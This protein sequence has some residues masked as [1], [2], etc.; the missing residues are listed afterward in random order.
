[1]KYIIVTL[2]SICSCFSTFAQ[3]QKYLEMARIDSISIKRAYLLSQQ[4]L[5]HDLNSD[6]I[7][8][9]SIKDNI[10]L[11]RKRDSSCIINILGKRLPVTDLSNYGECTV[12]SNID[13]TEILILCVNY[14]GY[15]NQYDRF[16][17]VPSHSI[18]QSRRIRQT[19]FKKFCSGLGAYIGCDMKEIEKQ[20]M[21]MKKVQYKTAEGVEIVYSQ[22]L[23]DWP[24]HCEY[25]FVNNRLTR[26]EFDYR[27]P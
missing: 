3:A 7:F 5:G 23:P 1:M 16:V 21:M 24:Y 11:G 8:V 12:C 15:I 27:D 9:F 25:H 13:G 22:S 20:M 26:Y 19:S 6:S 14:G 4:I 18:T 17:V 2:I 10:I